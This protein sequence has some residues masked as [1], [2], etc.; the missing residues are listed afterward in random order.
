MWLL[1]ICSSS[2]AFCTSPPQYGRKPFLFALCSACLI[3]P[4]DEWCHSCRE[5]HLEL[6][7]QHL[8]W[9]KIPRAIMN[10]IVHFV[11][12]VMAFTFPF[13]AMLSS[14]SP[15]QQPVVVRPPCFIGFGGEVA[16]RSMFFNSSLALSIGSQKKNQHYFRKFHY[17]RLP[18]LLSVPTLPS[19]QFQGCNDCYSQQYSLEPGVLCH[20]QQGHFLCRLCCGGR[21]FGGRFE[22]LK[23]RACACV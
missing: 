19:P 14:S 13:V 12:D 17:C 22:F 16:P 20:F 3:V 7:H 15:F 4:Y 18:L 6:V 9:I 11:L 21:L 1:H 10:M 2:S 23:V 8:F 5:T